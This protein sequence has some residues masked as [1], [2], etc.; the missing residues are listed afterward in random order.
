MRHRL[1]VWASGF[2]DPDAWVVDD[3]SFPRTAT[4]RRVWRGCTAAPKPDASSGSGKT[5]DELLTIWDDRPDKTS[6]GKDR[7]MEL[8]RLTVVSGLASHIHCLARAV[9]RLHEA[10]MDLEAMPLVRGA[11][12]HGLT[13]QWM[14]HN[15]EEA[16]AGFVNEQQ[17]QR[18]A[19]AKAMLKICW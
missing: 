4:P 12:E 7:P 3:T 13:A 19:T 11:L 5:L 15:E 9:M 6:V 8:G 10:G 2:V 1:A 18:R 17:R 16:L 14:L